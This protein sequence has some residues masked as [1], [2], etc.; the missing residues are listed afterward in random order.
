[1][2]RISTPRK[3]FIAILVLLLVSIGSSAQNSIVTE[4]VLPGNPIAEWGVPDFRDSRI[5]GFSTKMSLNSGE[6]ARFKITVQPAA[7]YTIKIYRIGYY[8][9]NGAR[10]VQNLGAFVGVAQPNG[11]SDPVTGLLDCSNWSESASWNIPA[12]AVSGLYIAK[13]ER[14][15][16]GSNHIAFI[17][18]NDASNSDLYL[19]FPDATWQA[20]NGYG[21][22]SLYDGNTTFPSGHAVKVSYNRPFFPYNSLFNTDG[23][24]SD[25]Y[26]NAVY[27][28]IRWLEHNGYD[29]TYTSC[30]DVENNGA[31]LLN[32]KVF[33]S[34][35][36]DE[37]W[38]KNHR[39]NV[40]AARD[41]GVNLAFFSGN[42][43]Y[44]KTRWESNDGTE[45]RVLVC[46][47]EGFLGDGTLGE[48]ACGSK[49][50]VSST[51]WT[52]LWRTGADY[53]AGLP[54]NTLTGQISWD[55]LPGAIQVPSKYKKIRFWR[56]TTIPNLAN[57]QIATLAPNT[58]G[59][60]W[61][62]EQYPDSYPGGRITM[63][64]T[65][66]NN[67]THKLSL[68]R[69]Q[70]GALVFGAGTI[71]WS[72]G[73]DG[74]HFGGT[75]VVS[76]EM[77][78]ATVNLFADMDVQPATLQTGLLPATKSTDLT[79]PS[80]AILSPANNSTTPAGAAITLTGTA[81]D[82]GGVVAGVEVSTDGGITW[83][84]A[85]INNADASITWSF[86]WT[87]NIEGGT[88]IRTRAFDDN[89]NKETPGAGINITVTPAVCPCTI[90]SPAS[91]P[92]KPLAND[93]L[94][95][96]ALG[97]R[98]RSTQNGII[99]GIRYYKGAGATGTHTGSLWNNTGTQLA[100]ATFTN[101]TASGWQQVLFAA[102]VPITA[103]VTYVASY[104]SSSGDYSSTNPFFNQPVINSPLKALANGE[105]GPNG[106]YVYSATPVFPTNSFQSNNYWV[107][108]VFTKAGG[109]AVPVVTRQPLSQTLCAGKNVSFSSAATGIPSPA[110]QWQSSADG[111]TWTNITGATNSTLT[112]TAT[113]ADNN[114][115]Y[116]AVW[117]NTEAIVNSNSA[118]LT[119]NAIPV[120][121]GGLTATTN[122]GSSFTYTPASSV[123]ATVFSWSRTAVTGIK[124]PAAQGTGNINEV[125]YNTTNA[126]AVVTYI[127]TL[128]AKGCTNKQNL[129]VTVN[130]PR[131]SSCVIN[132]S[133]ESDFNSTP[134]GA[135]RYIWFNSSFRPGSFGN[136][137]K[138][139]EVIINVTNSRITFKANNKQ[140]VLPVPD[141]RI[142]FDNRATLATTRFINN[143]WE[144]VV[145]VNFK[146]EV[147]MGGLSY[148]VPV[149][150]PGNIKDVKWIADVS[151]DKTDI[152][153]SWQ[154]AASVYTR[155][156]G[157]TGLYIKPVSGLFQNLYLNLDEA[158]TPQ[159]YK[160]F[161]TAG[162]KGK[163]KK[164]YTGEY[165]KK[166]KVS[167]RKDNDDEDGDDGHHQGDDD[168]DD[169][170]LIK[171]I[172]KLVGK[173]PGLTG[174][175]AVKKL[176]IQAAPN[177]SSSYV[178]L[179]IR[180][181][182][183]TTVT[184]RILD[185]FGRVIE[186]HDRIAS[187]SVLKVGEKWKNGVY[188]A[189]VTQGDLQKT[190][191]IIKAN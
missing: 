77:Q 37:Y 1:M 124:N 168:R 119:V 67:H 167:C 152:S 88:T 85:E 141:S 128:T 13:L 26:M 106:V 98:F 10:L 151:I 114:K 101:E 64:S 123:T 62:F 137:K 181:E 44:W 170:S 133:I 9:G 69:H 176:D 135:G 33:I 158:G 31:R 40:E 146:K 132:T 68:Y 47:K 20:Y 41:A 25:W 100:T 174:L 66:I 8:G 147:F 3:H 16:G 172:N 72:W 89:G 79:A 163:G 162:A 12:A 109:N 115:K 51:E 65:T 175:P 126:P 76:A 18:R 184:V 80:S 129:V 110:V 139:D 78:Q 121:S 24:E 142:R 21:G 29:I 187:N 74:N 144:T 48:R 104:H 164:N 97:V 131:N 95:G 87:P 140:Y 57:G 27:P 160:L 155:F 180:G 4:N 156:A 56:N 75:A 11:M 179:S 83:K 84:Q 5:A 183:K 71:Q 112:F 188:F 93:G 19:Q 36:H 59:H 54:E 136:L 108:V 92:A 94:G 82:A 122:S 157:N 6:T 165:S 159:N 120:L 186:T 32:H 53:D 91:V 60:E 166:Q 38:S 42:E 177:P 49:C 150:F 185:V 130:P 134:I 43:V 17:V 103:G 189:I 7:T 52:G 70:S 50:D 22:N 45:D 73:L 138:K 191:K 96:I 178:N 35:G 173:L 182:I 46:Y 145:P 127:Y 111:T 107:D 190:I 113:I 143:N 15:G 58:L 116:R 28:M 154:W 125:L 169:R 61:D 81:T 171:S 23:R 34:A 30:N 39:S 55:E 148:M 149:N 153:L 63:S 161:L 99:T 2:A 86:S 90:F 118:V 14:T 105:D 102:P 117:Q